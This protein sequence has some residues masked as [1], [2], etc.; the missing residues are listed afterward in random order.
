MPSGT[1]HPGHS[2]R[3]RFHGEDHELVGHVLAALQAF[4]INT[5]SVISDNSCIVVELTLRINTLQER[6]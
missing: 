2:D 6:F 1:V 4:Q 5:G 3:A